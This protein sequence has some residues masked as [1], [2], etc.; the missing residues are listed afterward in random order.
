MGQGVDVICDLNP[1]QGC[2]QDRLV[3]L[4]RANPPYQRYEP[5]KCGFLI[6]E[7]R[8]DLCYDASLTPMSVGRCLISFDPKCR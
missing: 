1:Q 4:I 3:Q 5:G 2:D 6:N 7:I 8:S